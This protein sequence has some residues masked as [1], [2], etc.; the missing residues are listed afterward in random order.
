LEAQRWFEFDPTPIVLAAL[1]RRVLRVNPAGARAFSE[2]ATLAD[3]RLDFFELSA[4]L[5][6][7]SALATIAS[8]RT[9]R[10]ST[11][12]RCDDGF[13]RRITIMRCGET[14]AEAVFIVLHGADAANP[15]IASLAAAFGLTPTEARILAFL[16]RGASAKVIAAQ[17][18]ISPHTVR[19]HLRSLYGKTEVRGL[20][21]LVR[22]STRLTS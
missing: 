22:E 16:S 13:W 1:D 12:L 6:F 9:D 10:V 18:G 11:I 5:A 21:D 8:G 20:C 3:G 14:R 4:R 7:D 2:V 19:A 17:L 15:D